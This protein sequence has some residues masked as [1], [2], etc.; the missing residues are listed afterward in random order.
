VVGLFIVAAVVM[1]AVGF[2]F[3]IPEEDVERIHIL[4]TK[5]GVQTTAGIFAIIISLSLMAI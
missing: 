3:L 4:Y 1:M 5:I 2:S